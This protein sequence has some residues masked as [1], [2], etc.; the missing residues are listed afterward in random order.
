[1]ENF[2]FCIGNLKK[3]KYT[4]IKKKLELQQ[5]RVQ[6]QLS[7]ASPPA[8][9]TPR[10]FK[11]SLLRLKVLLGPE[12]A[13]STSFHN[14]S[15]QRKSMAGSVHLTPPPIPHHPPTLPCACTHVSTRVHAHKCA[16]KHTHTHSAKGLWSLLDS[17]FQGHRTVPLLAP[18][19]EAMESP[20]SPFISCFLLTFL[21]PILG[22]SHKREGFTLEHKT[23]ILTLPA[24]CWL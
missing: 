17:S 2:S 15:Q 5:N 16:H 24:P 7:S 3:K 23:Q 19:A 13:A 4:H 8:H 18:K 21:L 20:A 10:A 12:Q 9:L 11:F 14:Q 22:S 6:L 1:M